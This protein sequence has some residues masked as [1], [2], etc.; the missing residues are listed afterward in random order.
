MIKKVTK[1]TFGQFQI[2]SDEMEFKQM[3][4]S[5]GKHFQKKSYGSI[6]D[7]V[8]VGFPEKTL[9]LGEFYCSW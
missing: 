5:Y 6:N 3:L 2:P 9:E 1:L 4:E 7:L 8:K